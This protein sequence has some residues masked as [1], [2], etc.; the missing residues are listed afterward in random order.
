M[1]IQDSGLSYLKEKYP[2]GYVFQTHELDEEKFLVVLVTKIE[3]SNKFALDSMKALPYI[4][5]K[6]ASYSKIPI[7]LNYAHKILFF[8]KGGLKPI[9]N[10]E[11]IKNLYTQTW[12]HEF[13]YAKPF[14][15]VSSMKLD[16]IKL[17]YQANEERLKKFNYPFSED[18]LD[19]KT[20]ELSAL[21]DKSGLEMG[22]AFYSF[23]RLSKECYDLSH[24][25][26]HHPH[27]KK[28]QSLQNRLY[29]LEPKIE[30]IKN[31][32]CE[33]EKIWLEWN[34]VLKEYL[35]R[36]NKWKKLI[37]GFVIEAVPIPFLGSISALI[38]EGLN[39]IKENIVG[40][41]SLQ[42]SLKKYE[43][44]IKFA[45]RYQKDLFEIEFP[46]EKFQ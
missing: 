5:N 22:K 30:K 46:E 23:L 27:R 17:V 21:L 35:N 41:K 14:M 16:L 13:L 45:E 3:N 24:E 42:K 10:I 8:K 32:V 28:I 29:L 18:P 11:L 20:Y 9:E 15:Q 37:L 12:I 4:F 7:W 43:D 1:N 33:R 19:K 34:L 38:S 36:K 26:S 6:K 25:I 40:H 39:E 2:S 44:L 31:I